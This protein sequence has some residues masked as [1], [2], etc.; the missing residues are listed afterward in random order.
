MLFAPK[1]S[2]FLPGMFV[3]LAVG[4]AVTAGGILM[5]DKKTRDAV[6]KTAETTCKKATEAVKKMLP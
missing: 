1:K 4:G 3:G 2:E 5:A 6:L